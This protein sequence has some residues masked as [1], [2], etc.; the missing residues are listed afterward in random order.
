ML[1]PILLAALIG[2]AH[3]ISYRYLHVTHE[4][5]SELMSFAA[6]ISISYLFLQFLPELYE[7][8]PIINHSVFL[9]LLLG[10]SIFH[11]IE[12]HHYRHHNKH[13]LIRNLVLW[14]RIGF[15]IYYF[16]IG[17]LLS[18]LYK[19]NLLS[20]VLLFIPVFLHSL[21]SSM[22]AAVMHRPSH[23]KVKK[24]HIQDIYKPHLEK[25]LSIHPI[26]GA[27]LP[28]LIPISQK[29]LSSLLGFVGGILLFIVVREAIPK[30]KDGRPAF[31]VIGILLYLLI[32][33][34]VWNFI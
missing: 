17:I 19:T 2:V 33:I 26:L 11:L 20:A 32:Q 3:L 1:I 22:S 5:K 28:I 30:E 16:V 9:F 14:H 23:S 13:D 27:L 12:K 34:I 10:F 18:V 15:S 7:A 31:F 4:S 6:G 21:L 24:A 25:Y 29:V 8:V